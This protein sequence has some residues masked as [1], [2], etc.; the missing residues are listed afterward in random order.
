[1]S[2]RRSDLERLLDLA[3]FGSENLRLRVFVVD[4]RLDILALIQEPSD[5]SGMDITH[6]GVDDLPCLFRPPMVAP[7]KT[8]ELPADV[9]ET[10]SHA[11]RIVR[12]GDGER[13]FVLNR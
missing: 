7:G 6:A 3:A 13:R 2:G 12:I 8:A 9:R 5:H 1:I 11:F 10:Q 4:L